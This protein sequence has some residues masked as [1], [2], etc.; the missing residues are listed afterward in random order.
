VLRPLKIAVVLYLAYLALM[1]LVAMPALNLLAPRLYRAETGRELHLDRII[2]LNPFTLAITVRN[3]ASDNPDH[4][5]FWAFDRLHADLALSSLWRR[6][7]VL[8]VVQLQGLYLQVEQ[9]QAGADGA[10]RYNFSDILDHR[11][12]RAAAEQA[13]ATTAEPATLFPISIG[14]IEL[15]AGH[16][17]VRAPHVAEPIAIEIG[18]LAVG[19]DDFST[20]A[21]NRSDDVTLEPA[22][23]A[24]D[25]ELIAPMHSSAI[26]IGIGYIKNSFLRAEHPFAAQLDSVQFNMDGFSGAA[27]PQDYQLRATPHAG[28]ELQAQG[29]F[30]LVRR[31]HAGE[32]HIK[33]FNLLPAWHYL[34]PRLAFETQRALL[35]ADLPYRVQWGEE[36]LRYFVDGGR[37]A[38][39]DAQLQS[40]RDPNTRIGLRTLEVEGIDVDGGQ[41]SAHVKAI[42]VDGLA[43]Q[44]WNDAAQI[45]LR[46]MFEFKSKADDTDEESNWQV[47]IEEVTVQQGQ[48]RWRTDLL[49]VP[50]LVAEPLDVKMEAIH[51]PVTKDAKFTVSTRINAD[52]RLA[53]DG[54]L[55]LADRTG[56]LN[57]NIE[58]VPLQWGNRLLGQEI[59]AQLKSGSASARFELT[60]DKGEPTR[61]RSDGRIDKLE[62]HRLPDQQKIAAWQSVEWKKLA[63]NLPARK[64]RIDQVTAIKPW[65]Q[66]RLN[67]DGT[68]NFQQL[69]MQKKVTPPLPSTA[70]SAKPPNAATEKPWLF[71]I[72]NIHT[73]NGLLDF[74]DASL[75]RSFHAT[76][77]DFTGDVEGLSNRNEALAKIAFKGTVDGYAPVAL[78]GTANPFASTPALDVTL[79]IAN[80]DLSTLTPYSGTYAGYTINGGRLSV[81]LA[82]SL[83]D[84]RVQGSN[85][86]VVNQLEL[87]EQV[88]GP[89]VM[90]LPLR[91]AI[92]L[93]T[94][95]KGVMDLG[96]DVTGNV[97]DPD[98]SV[99]SIIWKAFR[100]VIVKTA[101]SP[102]RALSRLVRGAE[103]DLDRVAFAPGSDRVLDTNTGKLDSLSEAL[104][105]KDALRL[106]ISG[107]VS[108]GQDIE[109]LRDNSLSADLI[110]QSRITPT[111]IQQQSTGWQE[112]VAKLYKKRF[113]ADTSGELSTMQMNDSMRDN[114]ELDPRALDELAGRRALAVKQALVTER[115]LAPERAAIAPVDLGADKHPG[116]HVT[117]TLE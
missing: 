83:K 94:D 107:H 98:F 37:I 104:R 42:R 101:S 21:L 88:S 15:D 115:G 62:M 65:V 34:A 39:R 29:R 87:G 58:A 103:E 32:I 106:S 40:E 4:S 68:N 67:P 38:L 43:L 17:G 50:E 105:Q 14:R 114:V 18:N 113:P 117:M 73:E 51:W 11:A 44:G 66:F 56:R 36:T 19:I 35:D 95:S 116:L 28:G 92:Y 27:Q 22:A 77:A 5:R 33:A 74:R 46:D 64:M 3:A 45:S 80:L 63:V 85:H 8:D 59:N 49:D 89:K 26:S 41:Q 30:D 79:D 57:G 81:Q 53:V 99:A 84:G 23:P 100:N 13:P 20:V 7:L 12:N 10:A 1:T 61:L 102:F 86:I 96:V 25:F 78:T 71:T 75:S 2:L 90:D 93:L 69:T 6:Q 97:D 24:L 82:Y 112:A 55:N 111:D 108:P 110:E 47:G 91:F 54:V 109:G 48:L 52:T 60:L 76:I 31:E 72:R 16:L 9:L 70:T